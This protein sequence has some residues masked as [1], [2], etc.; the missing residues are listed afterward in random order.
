M[1]WVPA[2][3]VDK[4]LEAYARHLYFL[5]TADLKTVCQKAYGELHKRAQRAQFRAHQLTLHLQAHTDPNYKSPAAPV[6]NPPHADDDV[7]SDTPDMD[8][9]GNIFVTD[10]GICAFLIVYYGSTCA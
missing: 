6:Q 2:G 9:E 8:F 5:A 10:E 4:Y 7:D 3:E 1:L